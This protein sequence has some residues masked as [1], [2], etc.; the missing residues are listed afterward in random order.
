M[1]AK[2]IKRDWL[3]AGGTLD[4]WKMMGYAFSWGIRSE[5]GHDRKGVWGWNV[6][7]D[8][9]DG[10][11]RVDDQRGWSKECSVRLVTMRRLRYPVMRCDKMQCY[12]LHITHSTPK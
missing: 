11:E 12:N 7:G 3:C 9:R 5:L 4:C 2:L 1:V 10:R 6:E 8:R